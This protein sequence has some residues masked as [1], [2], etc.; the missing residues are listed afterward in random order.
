MKPIAKLNVSN[1]Q[2]HRVW[3]YGTD[4][5]DSFPDETYVRPVLDL[6]VNSL[7]NRIVGTQL[8]LADLLNT[9]STLTIRR[10]ISRALEEK[11]N[12][13]SEKALSASPISR[14]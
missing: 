12:Q 10:R 13:K 1:L 8:T 7:D 2:V 6:P 3:E 14:L 9:K 4:L 11:Q 5:E